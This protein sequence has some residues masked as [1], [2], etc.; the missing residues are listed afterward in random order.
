MRRETG[1]TFAALAAG[2]LFG[3]GLVVSG[4][5]D[6]ARIIGFLDIA[7]G[8]DPTL[9]I[10]MAAALSVTALGYRLARLRA[11]PVFAPSFPG[12]PPAAIDAR[13]VGGAALFG[14]GWGLAG[15]CPGPAISAAALGR[16]EPLL[17]LAAMLA[18]MMARRAAFR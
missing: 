3:A 13:L 8:F 17:F 9:L 14:A 11:A 5:I 15:F 7:G 10:V 16:V 1:E 6:P 2:L 12:P 4:M 18:G